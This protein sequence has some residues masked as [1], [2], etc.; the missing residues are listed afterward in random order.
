M[1]FTTSPGG[2]VI[3]GRGGCWSRCGNRVVAAIVVIFKGCADTVV[4]ATEEPDPALI[5][6]VTVALP[7]LQA[8][9]GGRA[10]RVVALALG[11]TAW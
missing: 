5:V 7:G 1:E 2:C 3:C 11:R 8:G 10:A 6:G 4:F 9:A